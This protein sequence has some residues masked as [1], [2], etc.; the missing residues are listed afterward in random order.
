MNKLYENSVLSQEFMIG[1]ADNNIKSDKK[2]A[3]Y[4]RKSEK[5]FRPLLEKFITWLKSADYGEEEYGDEYGNEAAAQE[6]SKQP[7]MTEE[8]L[9]M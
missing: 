6:E 1:W 5:V 4:D 8:Q 7:V 2:C 9:R 3:L